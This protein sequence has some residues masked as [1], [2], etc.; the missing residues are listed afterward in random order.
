[1]ESLLLAF[2]WEPGKNVGP[3]F[4]Y[5]LE[6]IYVI[7]REEIF[8]E[9]LNFFFGGRRARNRGSENQ[10]SYMCSCLRLELKTYLKMENFKN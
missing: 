9:F 5:L 3:I 7:L 2:L 8:N 1:M 6:L 4:I 10:N